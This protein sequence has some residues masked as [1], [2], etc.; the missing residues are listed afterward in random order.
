MLENEQNDFPT[1]QDHC[2]SNGKMVTFSRYVVIIL[3][4]FTDG[5]LFSV[6]LARMKN[7][8]EKYFVI[9]EMLEII[10]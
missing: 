5:T 9:I 3:H 4:F 2:G 10:E 8:N 6:K 1:E 7:K